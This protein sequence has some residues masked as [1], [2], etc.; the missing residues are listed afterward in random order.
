MEGPQHLNRDIFARLSQTAL[1]G[2]AEA[3]E[4]AKEKLQALEGLQDEDA[5]LER[6]EAGDE[7]L[8]N[9]MKVLQRPAAMLSKTFCC[10]P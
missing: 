4:C 1:R 3:E 8:N 5:K 10:L 6:S 7:L 2:L 9:Y